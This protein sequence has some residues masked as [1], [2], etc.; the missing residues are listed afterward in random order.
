MNNRNTIV[1][2]VW[3]IGTKLDQKWGQTDITGMWK[4]DSPARQ[5]WKPWWERKG[6]PDL[7]DKQ[8]W[9][10]TEDVGYAAFGDHKVPTRYH[11]PSGHYFAAKIHRS[12]QARYSSL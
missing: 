2:Y 4:E 12:R 8:F 6:T 5:V 11:L 7:V 10:V 9:L 3:R 1:P